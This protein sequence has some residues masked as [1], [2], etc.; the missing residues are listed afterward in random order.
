MAPE[1][2]ERER[3][4]VREAL[5]DL[6]FERSFQQVTLDQLLERAGVDRPTFEREFTDLEECF[7]QTYEVELDRF[8]RLTASAREG[9]TSWRE[10]VRATAYALFHFLAEDEKV[11]NFVAVEVRGGGERVQLLFGQEIE[12]L[13]D[14]IDEGRQE[15]ADPASLSRTTAEVVGG[16]IFNQIYAAAGPQRPGSPEANLVPQM[17][18]T[19]L[20]PY[21]GS[22]AALEELDIP[23]PHP[24]GEV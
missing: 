15:L 7:L 23:P 19:V 21:L 20:L 13:I 1:T 11:T 16:G 17:M 12:A 18:Y 3:T 10:R 22:E 5:I 6:C 4:R 8:R 2:Q 24:F 9:L 14:L